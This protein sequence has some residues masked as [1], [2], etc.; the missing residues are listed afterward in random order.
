MI[1]IFQNASATIRKF[2]AIDFKTVFVDRPYRWCFDEMPSALYARCGIRKA[3]FEI[4]W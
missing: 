2:S 4:E 3:R 1:V